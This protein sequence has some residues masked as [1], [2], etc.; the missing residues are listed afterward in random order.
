MEMWRAAVR[1]NRPELIAA[2]ARNVAD[3]AG[4]K[5]YQSRYRKEIDGDGK[6][7]LVAGEKM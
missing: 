7:R 1:R 4:A 3:Y 2:Y 6:L 5:E